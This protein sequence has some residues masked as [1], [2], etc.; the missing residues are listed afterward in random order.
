MSAKLPSSVALPDLLGYVQ[1]HSAPEP[2][3]LARLRR[4]THL[5]VLYPR[6]LSSPVQGRLLALISRLLRPRRILEV[7]TFTGYSSIC[8]AEGLPADGQLITLEKNPELGFMIHPYLKAAGIS[9]Q[10]D[11]RFGP[12]LEQLPALSPPFDLAFIDADKGNYRSYYQR[13]M[14]LLRPGGLLMADNV[15]WDGKVADAQYQDKETRGIR[16]FNEAVQA[17]PQAFPL[18]LPLDDGLMLAMKRTDA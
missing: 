13:I 14:P 17:D 5:K 10:V 7:G 3:L 8:L 4:E 15:L 9:E 18:L 1:A 11:V 12:A 2:P 16:E 6:M